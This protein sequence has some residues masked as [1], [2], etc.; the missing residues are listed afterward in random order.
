MQRLSSSLFCTSRRTLPLLTLSGSR[1]L[2]ISSPQN[3]VALPITAT[4]PPPSA[5]VSATSDQIARRRR[6]AELLKHGRN[7]RA[8]QTQP[9]DRLKKRFWKDVNVK[10]DSEGTHTIHLDTRPVRNPSTKRPLPIPA[11]KPH[12]ATAIALEWDLLTSA[13]DTLQSHLLPLTS[14]ASRAHD[15]ILEESHP[16]GS[17]ESKT[18]IEI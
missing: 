16:S 12:L 4:G 10:T 15:I 5:P 2:H 18:R 17:S 14:L 8:D 3:A 9:E 13:K 7:L 1:S 11:S 6:R